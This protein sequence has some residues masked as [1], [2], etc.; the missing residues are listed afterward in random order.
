MLA[1]QRIIVMF[2]LIILAVNSSEK[3]GW[4]KYG[5]SRILDVES[6]A[7]HAARNMN[8]SCSDEWHRRCCPDPLFE[9]ML[10]RGTLVP[11]SGPS[12]RCN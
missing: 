8:C 5:E 12:C 4:I 9:P 11:P 2:V 1:A 7:L 3:A 10:P 6:I